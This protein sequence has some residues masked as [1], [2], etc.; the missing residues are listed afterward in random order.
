MARRYSPPKALPTDAA[1]LAVELK[2]QLDA[3]AQIL[4]ELDPEPGEL[5]ALTDEVVAVAAGSVTRLS[6]PAEGQTVVFPGADP[7]N[8]GKTIRL[9]VVAPQGPLTLRPLEDTINGAAALTTTAYGAIE[10]RSDGLGDW[11]TSSN[12]LPSAEGAELDFAPTDATYLVQTPHADLPN[13]RAAVSSAEIA[14]SFGVASVVSWAIVT[15]SIVLSKLANLAGLSVLGRASNTSGVMAPITASSQGQLLTVSAAPALAWGQAITASYTDGSVTAVKLAA[16]VTLEEVLSRGNNTGANSIEVDANQNIVFAGG[17][18]LGDIQALAAL[19]VRSAGAIDM[20]ATTGNVGLAALAGN[21][22]LSGVNQVNFTASAVAGFVR[23]TVNGVNRF[24]FTGTGAFAIGAGADRGTLGELFISQGDTTPIW[25]QAITASYTDGSVT[26]PKIATQ[27]ADTVVANVTGSPASP[28]AHSLA[29]LFGGGLSYAAGVAAVGGSSY[30]SVAASSID[31]SGFDLHLGGVGSSQ[32]KGIDLLNTS[33]IT[34]TATAPGGT[35]LGLQLNVANN[36]IGPTQIDETAAYAWTGNHEFSGNVRLTEVFTSSLPA[37]TDNMAIGNATIVRLDTAVLLGATVTGMVPVG[38]GH[39]VF[40][41]NV[42][43]GQTITL[44]NDATSTAANRFLLPGTRDHVLPPGCGAWLRY[45]GTVQR[46]MSAESFTSFS[47]SLSPT[48]H[49]GTRALTLVE[50]NGIDFSTSS[51]DGNVTITAAVD[52]GD[53]FA[54][55]GA[56]TWASTAEFNGAA[57]FDDDA[58]F[59]APVVF[60]DTI[61]KTGAFV[62]TLAAGTNNLAIGAVSVVRITLTGS[63]TLTGMVP[64]AAGQTV[65]IFNA[66][67][68]DTLTLGHLTT[69]TATN[70]FLCPNNVNYALPPRCGVAVWYDP[71]SSLW[72]VLGK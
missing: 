40:V 55:T 10:L 18:G 53:A 60:D 23:F 5:D 46:W 33:T 2:R 67:S 69:S 59:N 14:P 62:T 61:H 9:L 52:A 19:N 25:G 28:T 12:P 7:S 70:Q 42:D 45:D 22:N 35:Y 57:Q 21:F 27:A 44:A 30:I 20:R 63:Q 16:D 68:A 15:A 66:D 72:F 48:T 49:N 6:P 58:T 50:G 13:A 29:T 4:A 31:W 37:N 24:W 8:R 36:S 32:W 38:D 26:L 65:W 51:T 17:S 56:H 39:M 3:V 1:G 64:T 54:W 41:Q 11:L 47:V 34:W 71:T 43:T